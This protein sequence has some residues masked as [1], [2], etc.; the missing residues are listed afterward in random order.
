MLGCFVD[1]VG[2]RDTR[3]VEKHFDLFLS[4]ANIA[5]AEVRNGRCLTKHARG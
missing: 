2:Y 1:Y 4:N 3:L 5:Y